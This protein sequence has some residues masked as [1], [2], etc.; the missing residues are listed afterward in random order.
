MVRRWLL[1]VG[2]KPDSWRFEVQRL[3]SESWLL[4][5]LPAGKEWVF[6]SEI[7]ALRAARGMADGM[8]ASFWRLY[9]IVPG[10][11]SGFYRGRPRI[12]WGL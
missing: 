10:Y 9:A 7:E 3:V 5:D 12:L 11:M 4:R 8:D 6:Q 1:G 2:R